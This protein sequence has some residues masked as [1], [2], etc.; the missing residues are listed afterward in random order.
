M[1]K[2]TIVEIEKNTNV[3]MKMLLTGIQLSTTLPTN[4]EKTA[5]SGADAQVTPK[6]DADLALSAAPAM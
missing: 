1:K 4:G 2:R 6:L 3:R 5:P